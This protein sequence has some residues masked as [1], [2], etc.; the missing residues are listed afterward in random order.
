ML[1]NMIEYET[2]AQLDRLKDDTFTADLM[3]YYKD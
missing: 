1:T 3:K 2:L